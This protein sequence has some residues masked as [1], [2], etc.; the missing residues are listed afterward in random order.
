MLFLRCRNNLWFF[1]CWSI[2]TC[3]SSTMVSTR[4]STRRTTRISR[5][6][7]SARRS[8]GDQSP[9]TGAGKPLP[10]PPSVFHVIILVILHV[11]KKVVFFSV[12]V[13]ILAYLTL[14]F[15]LSSIADVLPMPKMPFIGVNSFLNLYF[16]KLGWFWTLFVS[17]PFVFM[18]SYTYCCGRKSMVVKHMIR[19]LIA[20]VFWY[21][22]VNFFVYIEGM[23]GICS[24]K[25]DMKTKSACVGSNSK[26]TGF[27]LS[28]HTFLL[29]YSN[30][31]L[32]EEMRPVL[33][34]ESIADLIRDEAHGRDNNVVNYGPLRGLDSSDFNKT[35]ILYN[36]FLPWVRLNF[37]LVTFLTIIWDGMLISTILYFHSMPEKLISGLVAITTW[38]M[39]YKVFYGSQKISPGD[40]SFQYFTKD[41]TQPLFR[42]PNRR[43]SIDAN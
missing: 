35:K 30:L 28:G 3:I 6:N 36:K 38:I 17:V 10:D 26:W 5:L 2:G 20:T 4:E 23:Y 24:K 43:S 9:P 37:I 1:P 25:P 12:H 31:I 15:A 16:V 42:Q 21:V 32:I 18:T 13:R 40:G 7:S 11:C 19:L 41:E 8:D 22:W 27:D 34:W 29:I 33:G 14:L 39:T